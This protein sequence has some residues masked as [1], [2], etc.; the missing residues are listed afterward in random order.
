MT[1]PSTNS[2]NRS[3]AERPRPNARGRSTGRVTLQER[4]KQ[5]SREKVLAAAREVF[6]EM[7]YALVAVEDIIARA[8]VS[9]AT[10]YRHFPSKF[11]VGKAL[12]D[13]FWPRLFA[14]YRGLAEM[15]DSGEQALARWVRTILDFYRSEKTL[16]VAFQQM[17]VIEP[18]FEPTVNQISLEVIR[19]LAASRASLGHLLEKSRRGRSARVEARLVLEQL[20][21]FLYAAVVHDWMEEVDD[22]VR[23]MARN[24]RRLLDDLAVEAMKV[25]RRG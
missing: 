18:E 17:M 23:V 2:R 15:R 1:K 16:V 6:N 19:T 21:D 4:Q 12:H 10:F 5:D 14:L 3:G 11:A 20:D 7:P 13:E 24:F 22:G 8:G 25:V 9:R